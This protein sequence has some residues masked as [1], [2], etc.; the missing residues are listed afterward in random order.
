MPIVVPT[1]S[2]LSLSLVCGTDRYD[3]NM[4]PPRNKCK[5]L[6]EVLFLFCHWILK[7]GA[8]FLQQIVGVF[9]L[10]PVT[11]K[12]PVE[13]KFLGI[14]LDSSLYLCRAISALDVRYPVCIVCVNMDVV[15]LH[16]I[17]RDPKPCGPHSSSARCHDADGRSR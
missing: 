5:G 11:T 3:I 12:L 14:H 2:S 15:R 16:D 4:M 13:Q 9:L 1:A 8:E 17:G 6:G 7:R 10:H